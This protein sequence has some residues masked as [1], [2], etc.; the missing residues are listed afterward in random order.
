MS[1]SAPDAES[2]VAAPATDEGPRSGRDGPAAA[3]CEPGDRLV[4][5][6]LHG[7][8][9]HIQPKRGQLVASIVGLLA[10]SAPKRLSIIPC[11]RRSPATPGAR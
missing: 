5:D 6:L 8:R 9:L 2:A 7:G 11:A 10:G 3:W 1:E 4:V